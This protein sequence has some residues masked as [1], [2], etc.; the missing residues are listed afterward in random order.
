MAT[1]PARPPARVTRATKPARPARPPA[2]SSVPSSVPSPLNPAPSGSGQPS[3]VSPSAAASDPV[4]SGASATRDRLIAGA[5]A[6]GLELA[7]GQV[8]HLLAYLALLARWNTVYNLT[9]LRDPDQMLAGHVLDTLAAIAPLSKRRVLAGARM[10]DVGS[11]GGIP[12]LIL[13]ILFPQSPLTLIEPVGKKAAFL[14][15]CAGEL[16][17][18][19]VRVVE[20]RAETLSDV[21]DLVIC[22]A[23]ASLADFVSLTRGLCDAHTLRVAM[24]GQRPTAELAELRSRL[25][26]PERPEAPLQAEILELVVPELDAHRHL[27]LLQEPGSSEISCLT[28]ATGAS[29]PPASSAAPIPPSTRPIAGS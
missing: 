10:A 24:K 14:R 6:L 22:R 19:R 26:R 13:A 20:A 1:Q 9:A 8:D 17:L 11:G 27:V 18:S 4:G 12:G 7:P 29:A 21:Q 23:F 3:P 16:G 25:E 15:Q 5:R 2:R 28:T